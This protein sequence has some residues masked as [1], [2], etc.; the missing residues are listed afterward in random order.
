MAN[1]W[2]RVWTDMVNDPKWRTIARVSGRPISEVLSVALHLM[3]CASNATERGRTEGWSDEDVATALDIDTDHV[4]KIKDAMQGRFLDGDQLTSW[5]KR[6]PKRED[7]SSERAKEWREAKKA[8]KKAAETEARTHANATERTKTPRRDTDTDTEESKPK[9]KDPAPAARM[10]AYRETAK[11]ILDYLNF[12]ADRNYQPIAAHFDFII[13]RL[14]DGATE[15]QCKAVIDRKCH[16]WK[17]GEK[18]DG[19]LQPKTLFNKTNF[20]NYVG[21]V[22]TAP[23]AGRQPVQERFSELNYGEM[24]VL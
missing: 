24:S 19:W 18:T 17:G 20:A 6:Q 4:T 2:F 16:E 5:D 10:L 14:K 12:K 23:P 3:T 13:A 8:E 9:D 15:A 21:A 1:P 11:S 22:G 7:N